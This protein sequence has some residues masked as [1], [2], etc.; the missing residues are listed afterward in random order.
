[1]SDAPLTTEEL[2]RLSRLGMDDAVIRQDG[3]VQ[4]RDMHSPDREYTEV[5][6]PGGWRVWLEAEER[7]VQ[8]RKKWKEAK[9]R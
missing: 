8:M 7:D 5:R 1:M 9:A 4:L 2:T 3:R 6:S